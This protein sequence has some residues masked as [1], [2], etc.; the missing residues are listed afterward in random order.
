ME[1]G[2]KTQRMEGASEQFY[3]RKESVGATATRQE[4]GKEKAGAACTNENG[5]GGSVF[6]T[7]K[8]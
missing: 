5:K 7:A 3:N 2:K 8:F 1:S 4:K 6:T